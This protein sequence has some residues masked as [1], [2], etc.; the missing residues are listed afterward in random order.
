MRWTGTRR[1]SQE[2]D[3]TEEF[4][5]RSPDF[6]YDLARDKFAQQMSDI[7]AVDSKLGAFLSAGSAVVGI[8]LAV[9]ALKP[10]RFSYWSVRALI[11]AA[12]MYGLLS[13]AS[14]AGL[15]ARRWSVGPEF[16]PF[17]VEAIKVPYSDDQVKWKAAKRYDDDFK[18]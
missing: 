2:E 12:V 17:L 16:D 15:M 18:R 13:I 5:A 9:Y 7:D 11:V 4:P 10:D 1:M 8:Q 3:K 14:V 6:W